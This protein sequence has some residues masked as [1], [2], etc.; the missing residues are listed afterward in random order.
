[1]TLRPL[2]V[3]AALIAA[4]YAHAQSLEVTGGLALTSN[5][6]SKGTSLSDNNPALQGYVEADSSGA[7]VGLWMSSVD[8][9]ADNVEADL[10][11]GYRNSLPNGLNYDI[12]YTRYIYDKSGNC[13]GEFTFGIDHVQPGAANLGA[14]LAYDPASKTRTVDV[15]AGYEF[16]DQLGLSATLGKVQRGPTFGDIGLTYA[17][18]DMTAFDLRYHDAKN[19]KGRVVLGLNFDTTLFS[20]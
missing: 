5:Y 15:S 9:G 20:R 2:L 18:S 1:M 12:G 10:Y 11:L 16:S 13:C 4:P 7:Y 8:G 3:A 6:M 14:S 17:V 19:D